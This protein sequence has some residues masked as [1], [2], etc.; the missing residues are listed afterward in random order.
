MRHVKKVGLGTNALAAQHVNP[1]STPTTATSRWAGF[2]GKPVLLNHH[3]LDE[4]YHLCC[5]S[6]VRADEL[7]I[8]Y[9]I[10]HVENKS[11][12]PART[13]DYLNLAASAFD[14][15]TGLQQASRQGWEVFGGHAPGK[16]GVGG[17]I[18]MSLFVSPHEPDCAKYFT[19]TSDG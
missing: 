4:Q 13:F 14:S 3:L 2:N 9:H 5:Y 16:R 11:Q 17:P 8:G 6:E 10:E 18:D 12:I 15:D 7:G 1:P 19:Y